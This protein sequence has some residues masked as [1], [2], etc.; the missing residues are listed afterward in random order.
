[1][2][3][4]DEASEAARTA[5]GAALKAGLDTLDL[6]QSVTFTPYV[7]VVLPLDGYV[8]WVNA[9]VASPSAVINALG[10]NAASPNSGS[11]LT[12]L[13][14]KTVMGAIHYVSDVR[15]EEASSAAVN[16][17]VFSAQDPVENLNEVNPQILWLASFDGIRFSFNARGSYFQQSNLHHY[18]GNAVYATMQTQIVDD[19][20]QLDAEEAIVSNSLPIW[21]ALPN[22]SPPWPVPLPM[23]RFPLYP[24]FLV[25]ANLPP[26]YGVVHVEPDQTT[27]LQIAPTYDLTYGHDMLA[28]DRVIVTLYGCNNRLAMDWYDAVLQYSYDL[29]HIGI[30]G[31]SP[32]IRD[33]KQTQTE[34]TVIAQK[35]RIIFEVCY[36]QAIARNIARQL[37]LSAAVTVMAQDNPIRTDTFPVPQ[38]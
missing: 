22:Y 25:P 6:D 16:R 15:Q 5:M 29:S 18:T 20:R 37:I 23:P 3:T 9:S 2:A 21:L 35:K 13:Q 8:F 33:D 34:M 36:H 7:R 1:M 30:M 31:V 24:S 32:I 38:P 14:P 27:A 4:V 26:I 10:I 11:P 28:H 12:L 19:A 17:V